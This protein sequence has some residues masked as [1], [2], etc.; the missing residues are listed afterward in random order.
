ML[1]QGTWRLSEDRR[2][3]FL[4]SVERWDRPAFPQVGTPG[5]PPGLSVSKIWR[6]LLRFQCLPARTPLDL[7]AR[8][9]K[10][11]PPHGGSRRAHTRK[12][13]TQPSL[14]SPHTQHCKPIFSPGRTP[15]CALRRMARSTDTHRR[16]WIS[17]TGS[18]R[19]LVLEGLAP[20]PHSGS[21][22]AFTRTR[23]THPSLPTP[24]PEHCKP[25]FSPGRTPSCAL[26]RM[27]RSVS[28]AEVY[29]LEP[30]MA[31]AS[32][33]NDKQ[34]RALRF[35]LTCLLSDR[36]SCTDTYVIYII[37]TYIIYTYDSLYLCIHI[38]I[39]QLSPSKP[40]CG[41]T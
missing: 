11:W 29:A 9:K 36:R 4:R 1:T 19:T 24:H 38:Y 18:Q 13:D 3:T 30:R 10:L 14:P 6:A 2:P 33:M 7:I 26:R 32:S 34:T 28:V 31:T 40:L 17:P 23:E 22:G 41:N 16:R 12:R 27:G 20:Q 35:A 21:E 37:Y 5:P 25:I 8:A 39:S 15:S